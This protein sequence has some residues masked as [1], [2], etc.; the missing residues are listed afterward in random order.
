MTCQ[1][2]NYSTH[3]QY[4]RDQRRIAEVFDDFC[5]AIEPDLVDIMDTIALEPGR[6]VILHF[7]GAKL[8]GQAGIKHAL[9]AC[10]SSTTEILSHDHE[11]RGVTSVLLNQAEHV[12]ALKAARDRP[13]VIV[14]AGN[15]ELSHFARVFSFEPPAV[16]EPRGPTAGW[17][18]HLRG[19]GYSAGSPMVS[20]WAEAPGGPS[21]PSAVGSGPSWTS[22]SWTTSAS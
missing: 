12:A 14:Q 20:R 16:V 22:P 10:C 11:L 7:S 21:A 1:R 13:C 18:W 9:R 3:R 17:G 5:D 19:R 4:C 8:S 6:V 2:K 15:M